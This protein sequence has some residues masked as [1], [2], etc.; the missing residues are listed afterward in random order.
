V[1]KPAQPPGEEEHEL[2][3]A[4]AARQRAYERAEALRRAEE[5]NSLRA[6]A[7]GCDRRHNKYWRF[8]AAGAE[9]RDTGAGR[10][11]VECH[12]SGGWR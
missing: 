3:A 5:A 8:V 10:V 11:Y 1:P 12:G 4:A 6:D 9:A 7:L 2:V